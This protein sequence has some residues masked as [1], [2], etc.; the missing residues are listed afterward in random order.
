MPRSHE[1]ERVGVEFLQRIDRIFREKRSVAICGDPAAGA[2][3]GIDDRDFDELVRSRRLL[4][5]ALLIEIRPLIARASRHPGRG[6]PFGKDNRV[7]RVGVRFVE[8]QRGPAMLRQ[9]ARRRPY[10]E[11]LLRERRRV[12]RLTGRRRARRQ[13]R[14]RRQ[15]DGASQCVPV[16]EVHRVF[17]CG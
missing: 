1:N 5:P 11:R 15:Y 16:Y 6:A 17:S 2:V 9:I 3:A 4:N 8:R 10:D 12:L 7:E 14:R 13:Y